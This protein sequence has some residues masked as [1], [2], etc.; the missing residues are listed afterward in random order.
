MEKITNENNPTQTGP[1]QIMN[2]VNQTF[3]QMVRDVK[4]MINENNQEPNDQ[5]S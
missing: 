4:N 2:R 1:E 3:D 5:L